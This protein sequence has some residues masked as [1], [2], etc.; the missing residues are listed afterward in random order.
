[1]GT[2]TKRG[3]RGSRLAKHTAASIGNELRD[4]RLAA[5]LAQAAVAVAAGMSQST[6][7]RVERGE[8]GRATV[9]QLSRVAAVLGL[10]LSLKLYPSG[11]PVRDAGQLALIGRFGARLA[12]ALRLRREVALPIQGDLRAWDAKIDGPDGSC[13]V[14]AEVHL[15]DAQALAMKIALKL[16]DDPATDR[17]ILLVA[18][19]SHNRAVLREHREALRAEFPL[20]GPVI[21]ASLRRGEV[22]KASG[23][24]V[25]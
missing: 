15:R 9:D 14:E 3:D 11:T 1:M 6:V 23:I 21:L 25:L 19:S 7:S 13:A 22:P 5:G 2:R 18:R 17:V 20:D 24:L 8:I 4:A 16:R 12:G 10:T